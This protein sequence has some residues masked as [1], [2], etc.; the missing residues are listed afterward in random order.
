MRG[1]KCCRNSQKIEL[2]NFAR[3]KNALNSGYKNVTFNNFTP[4]KEKLEIIKSEKKSLDRA[5]NKTKRET[6][7]D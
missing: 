4:N 5:F 2:E 6:R 3:W 7:T 1:Q